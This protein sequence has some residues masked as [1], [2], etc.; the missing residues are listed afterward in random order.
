MLYPCSTSAYLFRI[1]NK[2][3]PRRIAENATIT[4]PLTKEKAP[5]SP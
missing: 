5:Q 1:P 2:V 3:F 4:T